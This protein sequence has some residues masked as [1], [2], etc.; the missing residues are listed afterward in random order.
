MKE[1]SQSSD[2]PC[3]TN[4]AI[5]EYT[6]GR[7]SSKVRVE[8][9]GHVEECAECAAC[10]RLIETETRLLCE[11]LQSNMNDSRVEALDTETLAMY[12][13]DSLDQ[14]TR[15]KCEQ[16]LASSPGDLRSLISL[17]RELGSVTS[18]ENNLVEKH[19]RPA[20]RIIRMPKR[21]FTPRNIA[22]LSGGESEAVEG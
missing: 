9:E 18:S 4:F 15:E 1:T 10:L 14:Q 12:L 17:R 19:V 16:I 20:G 3:F 13:D 8:L 21:Q 2:Q 5:Q 7:L 22:E 6:L 11:A